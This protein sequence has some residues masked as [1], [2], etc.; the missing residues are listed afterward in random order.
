MAPYRPDNEF[1]TLK[2]VKLGYDVY[3]YYGQV[4]RKTGL[5]PD[6][7]GLAVRADGGRI[8]EGGFNDGNWEPTYRSIYGIRGHQNVYVEATD[9]R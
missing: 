7:V 2:G 9:G 5:R 8:I 4:D 1:R 3:D 6:G